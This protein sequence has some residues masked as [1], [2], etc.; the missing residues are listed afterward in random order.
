MSVSR[1]HQRNRIGAQL[2][3]SALS[4][5]F[6]SMPWLLTV[7]VQ[8]NDEIENSGVLGFY[9]RCGF[10]DRYRVNYEEETDTLMEFERTNSTGPGSPFGDFENLTT[11][12]RPPVRNR[13]P[14]AFENPSAL[15]CA[16][17][18][19]GTTSNEKFHQYRCVLRSFGLRL[20][21]LQHSISLTE[22]QIDSV[23][24]TAESALVAEPL[25]LFSRFAAKNTSFPIMVEDTMLFIEHFNNDYDVNPILPGPDT[26]R[27]WMALGAVGLLRV[28][29]NSSHRAAK[30]V[31]QIGLNYGPGQYE[32]FRHEQ[33]GTIATEVRVSTEAVA[34]FPY[35]NATFFHSIFIPEGSMNVIAE[36][37][38][39]EFLK[40]DYRRS[41][42]AKAIPML[43]R[44]GS[45]DTQ[46]ALF[47][48]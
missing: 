31:C 45:R 16:S 30:Y 3:A 40:Y 12:P 6:E 9:R 32:Y 23:G 7:T 34:C 18:Y 38:S 15:E 47:G 36:M 39:N 8:T 28:L 22:P 48:G 43:R 41:C 37:D 2:V 26:K 25:K 5:Y 35:T 17:V 20:Q 13:L 42:I 4:L 21:R 44:Y 1:A 19:F 29:G 14:N 10:H 33:R 24:P 27:W 46:L 11:A